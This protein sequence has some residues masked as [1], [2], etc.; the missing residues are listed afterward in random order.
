MRTT[1]IFLAFLLLPHVAK[2]DWEFFTRLGARQIADPNY[3]LVSETDAGF[4]VEMGAGYHLGPH[5]GVELA[6]ALGGAT[7]PLFDELAEASLWLT[8]VQGT[9]V[10]EA[11]ILPWLRLFGRGG[12]SVEFASLEFSEAEAS[13][14]SD[15]AVVPAFLGT[16]GF[17]VQLRPAAGEGTSKQTPL[18][19][20]AEGG[21][22]F[23]PWRAEFPALHRDRDP[24]EKPSPAGR[25][26]GGSLGLAGWLFQ[27]GAG[28]H[29]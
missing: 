22:L 2:T 19:I 16:G 24:R 18:V 1:F 7:S 9:G 15:L 21:Y 11:P 29:F 8:S 26:P 23:A 28:I 4:R 10:V 17:K 25:V 12:V 27:L 14:I 13:G 20:S 6:A 3:A 5:F